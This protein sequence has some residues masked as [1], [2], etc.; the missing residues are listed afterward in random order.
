MAAHQPKNSWLYINGYEQIDEIKLRLMGEKSNSKLI[1]LKILSIFAGQK[2]KRFFPK[3]KKFRK[4][5]FRVGE[6]I[7]RETKKSFS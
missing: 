2:A 4:R 7:L 6:T 1:F 5:T 3:Q